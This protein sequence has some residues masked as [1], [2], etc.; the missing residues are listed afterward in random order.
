VYASTS[1]S[2]TTNNLGVFGYAGTE[3]NPVFSPA[4]RTGVSGRAHSNTAA[5]ICIGVY[6]IAIGPDVYDP[7]QPPNLQHTKWAGYFP[8]YT[9][10]P[11]GTWSASDEQLKLNIQEL[12]PDVAVTKLLALQPKTYDF[13]QDQFGFMHLP[14]EH[15]FGM[16]AQNVADVL[17][18]L[19]TN[20]HQPAELDSTGGV[21]H[22][23]VDFKAMSY[24]GFIPLLIAG[25][26][27]QQAT[28]ASLQ[29]QINNCCTLGGM[30]QGGN[31]AP[32][33]TGTNSIQ[34]ERLTIVPNPFSDHTTLHYYVPQQGKVSLQVSGSDGRPIG[35]LR[36]EQADAGEYTYEWNTQSLAAGMYY[37]SV[38]V[39]GK[40]VVM[41]GVKVEER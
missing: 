30:T 12:A 34:E 9:Y 21:V 32:V 6:G 13:N 39:D 24:Q 28:I 41:K 19:V 25:F 29:T 31:H 22:P 23:E 7:L 11:G 33:S 14:S 10:T 4:F 38:V 3:L 2:A 5:D 37:V 18:E 17:P 36:E 40:V 8:G 35:T 15:Q 1:G 26:Q 27:R 16:I 20:I